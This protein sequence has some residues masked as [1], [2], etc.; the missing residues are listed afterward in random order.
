MHLSGQK[1]AVWHLSRKGSYSNQS[2]WMVCSN[3]WKINNRTMHKHVCLFVPR[4]ALLRVGN[5]YPLQHSCLENSMD[6]GAPPPPPPPRYGR[7]LST[8]SKRV[9]HDWVTKHAYM[10]RVALT[11]GL[12]IS[13]NFD[14]ENFLDFSFLRQ[15]MINHQGCSPSRWG[16]FQ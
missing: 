4:V 16:D 3:I 10:P 9:R 11:R 5:G 8:G 6:S 15:W 1:K 7:L 12:D 14:S 2:S 13:L